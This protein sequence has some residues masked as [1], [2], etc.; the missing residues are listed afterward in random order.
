ML[1][2]LTLASFC[3]YQVEKINVTEQN[4][5]I[6]DN[7]KPIFHLTKSNLPL[8]TYV[9]LQSCAHFVV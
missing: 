3:L 6:V 2:S 9:R 1:I 8:L 5:S 4:F 7:N